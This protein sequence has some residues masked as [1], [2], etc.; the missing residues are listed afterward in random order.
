MAF[1][2]EGWRT[3][4]QLNTD[5]PKDPVSVFASCQEDPVVFTT[6]LEKLVDVLCNIVMFGRYFAGVI[7]EM[8]EVAETIGKELHERDRNPTSRTQSAPT[9]KC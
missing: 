9:M 3:L 7:L 1:K 2:K 4:Y 8:S 5:N 6:F